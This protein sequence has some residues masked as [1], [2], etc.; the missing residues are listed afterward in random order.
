M[1]REPHADNLGVKYKNPPKEDDSAKVL[2]TMSEAARRLNVSRT[3]LYELV[4]RGEVE[5]LTLGKLRRIT[6]AALD[7]FVEAKRAEQGY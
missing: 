4:N 7:K 5:S 1:G 6:P 2:L 3:Y